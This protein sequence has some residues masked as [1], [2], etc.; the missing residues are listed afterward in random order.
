MNKLSNTELLAI[1]G[2]ASLTGT[3]VNAVTGAARFIYSVGQA[4][5]SS[6]RR[7][8]EKTLCPIK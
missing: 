3:L 5:G 2:G 8:S 6:L 4:F 7:I 1:I